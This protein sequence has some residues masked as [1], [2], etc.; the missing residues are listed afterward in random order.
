ML[1]TQ[2]KVK[3]GTLQQC[4]LPGD[5]LVLPLYNYAAHPVIREY[6]HFTT[7]LLIQL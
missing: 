2:L 1:L 4:C 6:W 3:V 7:M 5:K